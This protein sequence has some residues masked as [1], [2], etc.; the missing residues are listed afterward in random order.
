MPSTLLAT[1]IT[2]L[3][4]LRSKVK[5][6]SSSSSAPTW[7]S[8]TKS[9][10][11]DSAIASS[12][13]AVIFSEIPSGLTSQPPVSINK[14]VRPFHSASYLTRS[15]VT[16]GVSSTI[17]SLRPI[18]RFTSVD[19]PTFG[20]PITATFGSP[21]NLRL[22]AHCQITSTTSGRSK[23][24]E[25]IS[26]A[27]SAI[28]SGEIFLVESIS[29]LLTSDCATSDAEISS[30]I[31]RSRRSALCSRSAYKKIFNCASGTTTVPISLPSTTIP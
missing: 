3:C 22:L 2:F 4:D 30:V 27:S 21:S 11:S 5:R 26:N 16:P 7:A 12:A 9:T 29:S 15:R 13:P 25:S 19:L 24:V 28:F 1:S 8:T 31:S 18:M 23:A 10:K 6:D 20:R 14:N 17:A